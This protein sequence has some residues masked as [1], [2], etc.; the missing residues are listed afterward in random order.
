MGGQLTASSVLGEGS[1][2]TVSLPRAPDVIHAPPQ[3]TVPASPARPSGPAGAT[4]NVLYIEDNPANV[5]VVS[6]FL[7][8]RGNA[9]LHSVGSGRAGLDSAIRDIP[10]IIL[11]DLHLPDLQGDRV[12]RELKAEPITAAIP[13]VVL[14]AD[15]TQGVVRRLLAIG[16]LAYLTKP[17]DLAELGELLDSSTTPAQ[18]HA[19]TA[20]LA[21]P[22]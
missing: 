11:L 2:F 16:A 20:T 1:A 10:D 4:I 3:D 7:K 17:L 6:R 13:V 8:G 22:A 14:S 15:A 19:R 21:T 18:D 12:L 5:E 9:R